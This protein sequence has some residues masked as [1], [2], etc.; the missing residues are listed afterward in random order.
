VC[1]CHTNGACR[2]VTDAW[3]SGHPTGSRRTGGHPRRHRLSRPAGALAGIHDG[4]VVRQVR[5]LPARLQTRCASTAE[6]EA[7]TCRARLDRLFD[8]NG[9]RKPL[10][11][12]D[13][14]TSPIAQIDRK[15][16]RPDFRVRRPPLNRAQ[17]WIND[18]EI[19]ISRE[20]R[21]LQAARRLGREIPT[22][23]YTPGLALRGGCRSAGES[24]APA[25]R[26]ARATPPIKAG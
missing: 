18:R 15:I 10:C 21:F 3:G 19:D 17:A 9:G 5:T 25:G 26:W 8:L 1:C 24:V 11:F 20:K 2:C 7:T 23:C 4:R 16:W 6:Q 12:L 22:L 14:P 13:S